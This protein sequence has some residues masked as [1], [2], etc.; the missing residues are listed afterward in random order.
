MRY[1]PA[2]GDRSNAHRRSLLR[3]RDR[4]G[5]NPSRGARL[6]HRRKR[7]TRL[8]DHKRES[9]HDIC[10]EQ[11]S[12]TARTVELHRL[13]ADWGEGTSDASCKR[14]SGSPSHCQRRHLAASFLQYHFLDDARRRLF[15]HGERKPVGWVPLALTPGVPRR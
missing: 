2:D 9:D 6:R 10:R 8:N 4:H 15:R 12:S 3:G 7:S 1:V 14:R 11:P 13:L 5:R